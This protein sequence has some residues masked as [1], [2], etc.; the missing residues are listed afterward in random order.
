L[1]GNVIAATSNAAR[2]SGFND[3][4]IQGD[5]LPVGVAVALLSLLPPHPL[6]NAV[7]LTATQT[8]DHLIVFSMSRSFSPVDRF[9]VMFTFISHYEFIYRRSIP[10]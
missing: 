4:S 9:K 3:V 1:S 10:D 7:K 8:P 6:N 5:E 2:C